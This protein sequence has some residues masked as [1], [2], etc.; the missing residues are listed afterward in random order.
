MISKARYREIADDLRKRLQDGEFPIGAQLPSIATLKQESEVPGLN[1]VRPALAIL[2]TEGLINIV[3]GT[4][5]FVIALPAPA[6]DLA[7]IHRDVEDLRTALETAQSALSRLERR[8][9]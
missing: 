1:T 4:G 6:G 5:T 3:H 8:L 9:G 7:A 2:Q